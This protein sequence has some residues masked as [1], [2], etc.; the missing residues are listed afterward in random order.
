MK[1][2]S[3]DILLYVSSRKMPYALRLKTGVPDGQACGDKHANSIQWCVTVFCY[4]LVCGFTWMIVDT[5]KYF[6]NPRGWRTKEIIT[7]VFNQRPLGASSLMLWLKFVSISWTCWIKVQLN[8]VYVNFRDLWN[9]FSLNF[10]QLCDK[11][12]C[13]FVLMR[14]R[15]VGRRVG[16]VGIIRNQILE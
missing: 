14:I 5:N 7:R 8:S 13:T 16:W 1:G 10:G 11:K 4:K 3:T 9:K 15:I 2:I 12:T 6:N